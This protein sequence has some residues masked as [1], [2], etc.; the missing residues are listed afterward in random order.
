MTVDS[1]KWTDFDRNFKD[2]T[3]ENRNITQGSVEQLI[4]EVSTDISKIDLEKFMPPL[5]ELSADPQSV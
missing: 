4:S 3:D 5:N 1:R 2:S